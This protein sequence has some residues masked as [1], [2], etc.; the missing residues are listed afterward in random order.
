MDMNDALQLQKVYNIQLHDMGTSKLY[1]SPSAAYSSGYNRGSSYSTPNRS[2]SYD[3]SSRYAGNVNNSSVRDRMKKFAEPKYDYSSNRYPSIDRSTVGR[4]RYSS[5]DRVSNR[6]GYLSDYGGSPRSFGSWDR[7]S[8]KSGRSYGGGSREGSPVSTRSSRYDYSSSA[9]PYSTY[10]YKSGSD[11]SPA[12]KRYDRQNSGGF[13]GPPKAAST[14]V[15]SVQKRRTSQ[16]SF[17]PINVRGRQAAITDTDSESDDSCPEAEKRGVKYL[18]CRG[19]SPIPEEGEHRR[20]RK[21]ESIAK[22]KRIKCP[23]RR[24]V[25]SRR[26]FNTVDCATQTNLDQQQVRRQRQQKNNE[27][28]EPPP[29]RRPR[30]QKDRSLEEEDQPPIRRPR[31]LRLDDDTLDTPQRKPRG[32]TKKEE[33]DSS[34]TFYKYRDKFLTP[35]LP[36]MPSSTY[37]GGGGSSRGSRSSYGYKADPPQEKSWRQ[38]VY[39]EL[40]PA[41]QPRADD[42]ETDSRSVANEEEDRS[43]RQSRRRRERERAAAEEEY[44]AA[45]ERRAARRSGPSRSS[46]RED[47][48]DDKPRRKRHSSKELLDDKPL[49]PENL[50]LRESIEKVNQ[51]KQQLP[52]PS[53]YEEEVAEDGRRRPAA[54]RAPRRLISR[55][56][57]NDSILDDDYDEGKLPNKDFRK[58]RLNKAPGYKESDGSIQHRPGL[59]KSGSSSEAISRDDSPNRMRHGSSRLQRDSSRESIL[60]DRRKSRRDTWEASDSAGSQFGFNREDSPNRNSRHSGRSGRTSRQSS[61]E[62]MLSDRS[63]QHPQLARQGA[64]DDQY[65]NRMSNISNDDGGRMQSSMSQHSIASNATLPDLVPPEG[66]YNH[67]DNNTRHI[68]RANN[69]TGFI[70][71]VQDIDS[72]LSDANKRRRMNRNG[73]S[74]MDAPVPPHAH[75][76]LQPSPV[77]SPSPQAG[78]RY[79]F[80]QY[81]GKKQRPNSYSFEAKQQ[82]DRNRVA[83][84]QSKSH[85]D[86]LIDIE[87]ENIQQET[88]IKQSSSPK[89]GRGQPSPTAQAMWVTLQQKKGLVAISDFIALCE[90]PAPP[91]VIQIPGALDDSN[92]NGYANANEM[93][94]NLGIDVSKVS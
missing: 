39:G 45:E 21:I 89:S 6:S 7:A 78:D 22:T 65:R 52:S 94:E 77:T 37:V 60:D 61:R 32:G 64:V 29:Q 48:L 58:S 51:W 59:K 56:G 8:S 28:D 26:G 13:D 69:R 71:N 46:S 91:K 88:A 25:I 79:D 34:K 85:D 75:A 84:R 3:P 83:M 36:A 23:K 67:P 93:L 86:K 54:D 87:D 72:V 10:S 76:P 74:I 1:Q 11:I 33:N 82:K 66:D 12:Q 31:G 80:N 49:T 15:D 9:S 63:H 20:D 53:Q 68:N 70:G 73:L 17:V 41:R 43:S 81:D 4:D 50:S 55:S 24:S 40:A 38:A 57:S 2:L 92:F 35:A 16:S 18:I 19:T 42:T 5:L 62:D 14:P 27:D 47:L 44:S 30:Q 90:K